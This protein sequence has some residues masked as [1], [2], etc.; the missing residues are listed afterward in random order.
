MQSTFRLNLKR[1]KPFVA[2]KNT[3]E[4]CMNLKIVKDDNLED[5][6]EEQFDV[7]YENA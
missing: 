6:N 5:E 2:T 1:N 4:K 7:E 3:L